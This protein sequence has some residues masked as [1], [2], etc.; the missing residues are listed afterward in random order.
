M[1]SMKISAEE[2]VEKVRTVRPIAR[3]NYGFV[4]IFSS[5]YVPRFQFYLPYL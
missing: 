5:F 3:P 2:A 4:S 1:T